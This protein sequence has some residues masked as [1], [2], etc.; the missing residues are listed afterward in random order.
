MTEKF[1]VRSEILSAIGKTDDPNMKMV[2]LLLLGVLEEIGG[3]LDEF[4]QDEHM[5][6]EK[7]LNGHGGVHNAHHDHI[8]TCIELDC[9]DVCR[10]AKTK[11]QEEEDAKKTQKSLLMKFLE[12]IVSHLGTAVAVAVIGYLAWGIKA[13]T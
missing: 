10:W 5:L 12:S 13:T 11:M 6:R 4:L 2:L 3:R 7:V 8:E 1:N 9:L